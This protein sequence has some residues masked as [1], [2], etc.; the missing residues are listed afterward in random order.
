MTKPMK[1]QEQI[2]LEK[3]LNQWRAQWLLTRSPYI[4][5]LSVEDQAELLMAHL[6]DRLQTEPDLKKTVLFA[7]I[8]KITEEE[9]KNH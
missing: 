3:I 2:E 1:T 4:Q 7:M 5:S 6:F 9:L 8:H